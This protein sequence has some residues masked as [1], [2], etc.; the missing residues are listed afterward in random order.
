MPTSTVLSRGRVAALLALAAFA[1]LA[2]PAAAQQCPDWRQNGAGINTDADTLWSPRSWSVT[3]GGPLNLPNCGS[4][5]GTGQI[6]AAPDFT[7]TYDALSRGHAL[8]FRIESQCDTVLLVN[9]AS[10]GWHFSD[11]EDGTLNPRLRLGNAASGIYDVWV[12]TY[13]QSNCAATL[14]LETFPGPVAMSSCPDWSLGGAELRM[15]SG[16]TVSRAVTAGGSVNLFAGDCGTSGHGYVAQ[17]PD[18]T[19]YYETR[20]G[21]R[22]LEISV[23]AQCDTVLLV[24]D[25]AAGW[26]F[27]D[28]H[29]S[30]DPQ[31][32]I[33]G[34]QTGRYDIWVG[35][36]GDALC[37][38]TLNVSAASSRGGQ[39]PSK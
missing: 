24:N 26:W 28:D 34:A 3:A 31:V 20:S 17:A 1:A 9:D 33:Q 14:V 8:E 10:A 23:Q 15:S 27:N 16:E 37:Q 2:S 12:G 32:T 5:P 38:A 7:V 18:F 22:P 6:T 11:D 39:T 35:T 19:L 13:G 25:P 4:V 29:V 30:L 21:R 36:Y